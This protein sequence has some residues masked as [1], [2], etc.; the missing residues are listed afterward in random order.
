METKNIAKS[1]F[2]E[3]LL[4]IIKKVSK[5]KQ[6]EL[7]EKFKDQIPD[8][9]EKN[10]YGTSRAMRSLDWGNHILFEVYFSTGKID[11]LQTNHWGDCVE[12]YF[13]RYGEPEFLKGK[14]VYQKYFN[15]SD[16]KTPREIFEL[17]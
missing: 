15:E 3:S 9:N 1:L 2:L 11:F 10:E 8:P 14:Y 4:F 17:M 13:I 7:M 5:E 16:L 6:L 12:S